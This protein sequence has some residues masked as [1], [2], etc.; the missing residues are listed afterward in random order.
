MFSNPYGNGT[1]IFTNNGATARK[2]QE[3]IDVGQVGSEVGGGTLWQYV[4]RLASTFLYRFHFPWC[5]SPAPG[6]PSLVTLTSMEN[7]VKTLTTLTSSWSINYSFR[8]VLLHAD[9]DS[10]LTV[11]GRWECL[12]LKYFPTDHWLLPRW[13]GSRRQGK[14]LHAS[15]EVNRFG[16]LDVMKT[17]CILCL[18]V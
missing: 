14:S 13:R 1:A 6:D 7:K 9:Q 5:H 10:H 3:Q 11:E 12:R 8:F 16:F 2:F 4:S 18:F 15:S 17:R